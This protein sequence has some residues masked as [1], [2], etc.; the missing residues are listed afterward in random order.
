MSD[1]FIFYFFVK[2]A[3][4]FSSC[5]PW[6]LR[7]VAP[8]ITMKGT[9]AVSLGTGTLAPSLPNVFLLG[10]WGRRE[11]RVVVGG[12][13]SPCMRLVPPSPSLG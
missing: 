5:H 4:I 9:L 1:F 13:K 8:T 12:V 3:T 10:G 7:G 6:R 2:N 11:G